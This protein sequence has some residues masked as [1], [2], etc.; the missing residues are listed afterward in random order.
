MLCNIFTVRII[1]VKS[2]RNLR[3][4]VLLDRLNFQ[5]KK[6]N[7]SD[8]C[9]CKMVRCCFFSMLLRGCFLHQSP[10]SIIFWW[11][12][13]MVWV[14]YSVGQDFYAFY[15]PK[16]NPQIWLLKGI[17]DSKM[18]I[19]PWFTHSCHFKS[20]WHNIGKLIKLNY[21]LVIF[22]HARAINGVWR[23]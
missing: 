23:F 1:T 22:F 15:P 9:L 21:I 2:K 14:A 5:K 12:L 11:F 16:G 3:C 4:H 13:N 18:K 19:V 10:V 17:A 20:K 6:K 8:S 7:P